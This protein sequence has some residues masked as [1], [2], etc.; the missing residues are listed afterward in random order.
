MGQKWVPEYRTLANGKMC[1]DLRFPGGLSLTHTHLARQAHHFAG[2]A[3]ANW[4]TDLP[5]DLNLAASGQLQGHL[6]A[7]H[8]K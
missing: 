2:G 1:Q 8:V 4:P 7:L 6:A 5:T 3:A